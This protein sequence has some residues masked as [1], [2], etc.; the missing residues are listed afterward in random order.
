MDSMTTHSD[1]WRCRDIEPANALS[2]LRA[3]VEEAS[4]DPLFCI[5]TKASR[6]W[7]TSGP[8]TEVVLLG[9]TPFS[10]TFLSEASGHCRVVGVLDDFRAPSGELF[11]GHPIIDTA[12]LLAMA[13]RSERLITVSG[14]RYDFSRRH[15]KR[16]TATHDI[17]HLNFEQAMRLL[18][19]N[20][21]KDHRVED[22]GPTILGRWPEWLQL[23]DRMEDEL[24]RHTLYGVLM[25]H[26]SCNPEWAL[27]IARP[28]CTLYFR[29][30]LWT[31]TSRERFADCGASIA[32][33][34]SALMDVT[35]GKFERIWMIEPDRKNVETLRKFKKNLAESWSDRIT[36]HA[37]ALSDAPSRMA[38]RHEGGHGGTL[39]ES[40]DLR[41]ED[42]VD[43]A[44][45]DD[46]LDMEPTLV[47]MDIEGAELAALQGAAA[48]VSAARP[49]LAL[50]AYH[51]AS[52]LLDLS[53]AALR[54]NPDYRI[55]LRHHTEERWDTCLYCY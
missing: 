39:A 41:A 20:P 5:P 26:L 17:P 8:E 49:K 48:C 16:L 9:A 51:R 33:S 37:C 25:T 19:L 7:N 13:G 14:C 43:V 46:L 12:T 45:L 3:M 29:S 4:S 47:K 2:L 11:E 23:A 30:G 35:D 18:R 31:T 6:I 42:Y 1:S 22:W 34:T 55:G 24:S 27:H 10:R 53:E 44:R 50:S 21:A 38:F 54:L 40:A 28:Y 15:F 52:D 32:E 36:I